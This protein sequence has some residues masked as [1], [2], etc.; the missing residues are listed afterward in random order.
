MY[1][2]QTRVQ[3]VK[4]VRRVWKPEQTVKAG[5]MLFLFLLWLPLVVYLQGCISPMGLAVKAM[6]G[7]SPAVQANIGGKAGQQVASF[8]NK[9]TNKTDNR[10]DVDIEKTTTNK[11]KINQADGSTVVQTDNRKDERNIYSTT[12][13]S[14]NIPVWVLVVACMGWL[15]PD[16]KTIVVG[17]GSIISWC[18]SG[19]IKTLKALIG[20]RR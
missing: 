17:L 10:Q 9:T 6:T 11:Q 14:T 5:I 1:T 18:V 16:V 13:E 2:K 3:R 4:R 8:E 15:L 12:N 7:G 19:T 20:L